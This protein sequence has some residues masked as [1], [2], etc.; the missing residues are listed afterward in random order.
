MSDQTEPIRPDSAPPA[1]TAPEPTT[2]A[3]TAPAVPAARR[4]VTLPLLPLGIVGGVI[5]ALLFFGGGVALGYGVAL[6][7][8]RP[9]N[10]QQYRGGNGEYPFGPGNGFGPR[11]NQN[12]QNGPNQGGQNRPGDRPTTAT[13]NG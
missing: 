2:P 13:Q 3:P 4:T 9:D 1:A 8:S 7:D 10:A 6:H 5:V 11:Q 12:G